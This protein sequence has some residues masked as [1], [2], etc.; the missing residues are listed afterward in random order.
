MF[1]SQIHTRYSYAIA[2]VLI[3]VSSHFKIGQLEEKRQKIMRKSSEVIPQSELVFV[4]VLSDFGRGIR[5]GVRPI[6]VARS[7]VHLFLWKE[8]AKDSMVIHMAL[9]AFY[10]GF[11]CYSYGLICVYE[12][13]F[14][15]PMDLFASMKDSFV[16]PMDL[17][18]F[19]KDSFAIHMLL[20]AYFYD[21]LFQ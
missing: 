12:R 15:I 16:I 14:V 9:F 2:K 21:G 13:I 4:G 20:I 8:I 6:S 10:E 19:I 17:F 1:I 3:V 7:W 18:A 5:H 11:H